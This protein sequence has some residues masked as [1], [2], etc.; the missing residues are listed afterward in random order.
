MKKTRAKQFF[1][2]RDVLFSMDPVNANGGFFDRTSTH[3]AIAERSK[4]AKKILA[5]IHLIEQELQQYTPIKSSQALGELHQKAFQITAAIRA[6]L[7]AEID[8]RS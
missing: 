7:Q 5:V 6:D 3:L 1:E 4:G 2:L 8:G